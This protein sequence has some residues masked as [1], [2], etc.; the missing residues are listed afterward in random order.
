MKKNYSKMKKR[1][2]KRYSVM[3]IPESQKNIIQFE[4]RSWVMLAASLLLVLL[5]FGAGLF[6]WYSNVQITRL[7]KTIAQD[8][9]LQNEQKKL[10]TR[11]DSMQQNVDATLN[12]YKQ[13]FQKENEI[14]GKLGMDLLQESD[15]TLPEGVDLASMNGKLQYMETVSTYVKDKLVILSANQETI[16][17][18]TDELIQLQSEYVPKGFPLDTM[19][20]ILYSFGS[21]DEAGNIHQGFGLEAYEQGKVLASAAGTVSEIGD[22]DA[23]QKI[24]KIDHG[25]GYI[26][27]Y[28]FSGKN[29]VNVGD[30]VTKGT[31]IGSVEGTA[32]AALKLEFQILFQG[33][34]VNPETLLEISG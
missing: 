16:G 24:I 6:A 30:A 33:Q 18:K 29:L 17:Q 11:L 26:S 14:R 3:V 2:T 5:L 13:L 27:V 19:S 22:Y 32:D 21:A 34:Y 20:R 9:K 10:N 25:N 4:I 23:T 12:T 15:F 28:I 31:N 1:L 8:S 7:E